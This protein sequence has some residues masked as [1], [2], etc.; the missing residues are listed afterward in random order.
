[1][2]GFIKTGAMHQDYFTV[3][4]PVEEAEKFFGDSW[5]M[6]GYEIYLKDPYQAQEVKEKWRISLA[7]P[8]LCVHG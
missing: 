2:I 1:V 3:A 7:F 5:Q 8:P 6:K 4:M